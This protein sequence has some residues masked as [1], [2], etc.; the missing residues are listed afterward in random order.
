MVDVPVSG[1]R[2]SWAQKLASPKSECH[3]ITN[4]YPEAASVVQ[5]VYRVVGDIENLAGKALAKVGESSE[6]T[7]IV[8]SA[9][10][11]E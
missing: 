1:F 5:Q 4:T 8:D 11:T 10:E 3:A 2:K 9:Y 7:S 6:W